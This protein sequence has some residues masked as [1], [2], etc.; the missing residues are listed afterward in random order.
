M[1]SHGAELWKVVAKALQNSKLVY[2]LECKERGSQLSL[3]HKCSTMF[4][5]F[6]CCADEEVGGHTN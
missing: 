2:S 1:L 6:W 4:A 3:V 5:L